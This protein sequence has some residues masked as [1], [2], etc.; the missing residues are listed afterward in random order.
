MPVSVRQTCLLNKVSI[1]A[2]CIWYDL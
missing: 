1:S 2:Q